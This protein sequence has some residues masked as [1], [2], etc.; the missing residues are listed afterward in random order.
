LLKDTVN[1]FSK[2]HPLIIQVTT[3]EPV[4]PGNILPFTPH[5]ASG[6]H[7]HGLHRILKKNT[8]GEMTG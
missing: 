6:D 1:L 7:Q 8:S 5:L 3:P 2:A 4:F